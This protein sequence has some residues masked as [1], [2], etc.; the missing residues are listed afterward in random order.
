MNTI[1][2]AIASTFLIQLFISSCADQNNTID[3]TLS[4]RINE[5]DNR[6][7]N[8][9]NR[10]EENSLMSKSDRDSLKSQMAEAF[11]ERINASSGQV[12]ISKKLL[13][14]SLSD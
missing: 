8:I 1:K 9:E 5:I 7:I 6:L 4:Q 2:L 3:D 14:R 11:Q 10:L 13:Q 12:F